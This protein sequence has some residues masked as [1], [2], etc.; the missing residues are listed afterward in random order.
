MSS[1]EHYLSNSPSPKQVDHYI[2]HKL[3][4]FLPSALEPH[5]AYGKI[6][7]CLLQY[8]YSQEAAGVYQRMHKN[9]YIPSPQTHA[10]MLGVVLASGNVGPEVMQTLYTL[11][12]DPHFTED[13][14][15]K[16][17]QNMEKIGVSYELLSLV[18]EKFVKGRGEG[19][20]SSRLLLTKLIDIQTRA[21]HLDNAFESLL[22]HENQQNS[23]S[24]EPFVTII[25]AL[26]ET[27]AADTDSINKTLLTMQEVK[28]Q[29]DIAVFNALISRELRRSSLRNAFSMYHIVIKFSKT[30]AVSPNASTFGILFSA[31]AKLF[32]PGVHSFRAP[33]LRSN[34]VPPRQLY[35]DLLF[36]RERSSFEMTTALLNGALRAFLKA[37]DYAG[38]YI[39][40]DSFQIFRLPVTA[41]TYNLIMQHVVRRV[42]WDVM[43]QRSGGVV[44]WGDRYMGFTNEHAVGGAKNHYILK[45]L[46]SASGTEFPLTSYLFGPN[47]GGERKYENPTIGMMDGSEKVPDSRALSVVPLQRIL[48]RALVA[49]DESSV[50]DVSIASQVFDD[51]RQAKQEIF[52]GKEHPYNFDTET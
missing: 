1:I 44:R 2:H 6:I 10:E 26:A 48:R 52:P 36:F 11:L 14:F 21:G 34:V 40:L 18:G 13:Q 50:D 20:T 19:Y 17:L 31:L 28:V 49:N 47:F 35:R 51:V 15:L 9:G 12:E 29:P 33:L 38:A 37:Q 27:K 43:M 46:E 7:S 32:K 3:D 30:T 5:I 25:K 23:L 24:T 16:L 4:K 45:I 39:V 41:K 8:K 22:R 42:I